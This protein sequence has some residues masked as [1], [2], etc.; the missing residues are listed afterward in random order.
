MIIVRQPKRGRI[1]MIY[2]P[3][4]CVMGGLMPTDEGFMREGASGGV[5]LK[6]EIATVLTRKEDEAILEY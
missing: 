5:E 1:S 4:K 2:V 3:K 6:F